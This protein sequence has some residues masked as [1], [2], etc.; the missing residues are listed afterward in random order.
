MSLPLAVGLVFAAPLSAK[1]ANTSVGNGDI[2]TRRGDCRGPQITE[3]LSHLGSGQQIRSAS[4][5]SD[6]RGPTIALDKAIRLILHPVGS[7]RLTRPAS[8]KYPAPGIRISST[9]SFAGFA[10]FKVERKGEYSIIGLWQTV[11]KD[12]FFGGGEIQIFN[13][14]DM[15]KNMPPIEIG[16]IPCFSPLRA[17]Y[18]LDSGEYVIQIA[19]TNTDQFDIIITDKD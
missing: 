6:P 9:V 1:S 18:N 5:A 10:S 8:P 13:N 3:P 16:D 4:Y 2:A 12:G 14:R 17:K 11:N 19:L 15:D 7:F